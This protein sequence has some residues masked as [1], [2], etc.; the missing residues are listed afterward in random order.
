MKMNKIPDIEIWNITDI[1]DY[2]VIRD[3]KYAWNI[4]ELSG[5]ETW[6]VLKVRVADKVFELISLGNGKFIPCFPPK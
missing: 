3:K 5:I 1:S 2:H 4:D 6:E